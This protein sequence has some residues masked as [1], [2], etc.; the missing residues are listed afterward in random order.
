MSSL[1]GLAQCPMCRSAVVSSLDAHD[2]KV[3][4]LGLNPGI[5]MM[6]ATVYAIIF[7]SVGMW[8]YKH[9]KTHRG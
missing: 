6:L 2:S 1:E 9:K 8:Y 4:G 5:L 7:I 3:V